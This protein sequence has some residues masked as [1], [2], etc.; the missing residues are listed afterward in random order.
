MKKT[1][2][3]IFAFVIGCL[4]FTSCQDP[5]AN[6]TVAKPGSYDQLA[7]Q[8]TTGF[9]AALKT[10]ISPLTIQANN[11][12]QQQSL[13]TCSSVLNLADTTARTQYQIQFS[14]VAS[15]VPF[16]TI[17]ITFDGKA[18]SDVT[19]GCKQFND[20][21]KT[22][23]KNAVQQTV[24]VRLLSFIVKKGLK[25]VYTSKTATLL[26]T[27]NNYAPT[28]V[29]DVVS[30]PM[31]SSI[32]IAVLTND[33]DPEKDA[34][35]TVSTTTPLHGTTVVNSDGT[36][37]YTPT[38]GY[39]GVDVFSYTISDG[40]GNTATANVDVTVMSILP[41]TA[42]TPRPY[43]IIGL[44]DGKWSNSAAGVG[45]SIYP[46]SVV[47]GNK[48]NIAGDGEFTF[49]GY[50]SASKGFKLIRDFGNWDE[51]WGMT[52]TAY[53]HNNGG[54]GNITVPADG[55]Y[56]ITLNSITNTLT[57]LPT[58]VTP[59][60]YTQIGLIGAFNSWGADVVM[61]PAE[62]TNN[63]VWYTTQT[64]TS[65]GGCKF[66]ANGGWTTSWGGNSFPVGMSGG[67][68]PAK[69][70]TYKVLFNDVE[71]CYYFIKQ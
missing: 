14:K 58:L 46:M 23:N 47:S 1:I 50:F 33:T 37:T 60:T 42:V 70:G 6:Q 20:S 48:Y 68:I 16:I 18:G 5:Y 43:Y 35:S 62:T 7:L 63:H 66:R 8:D 25:T 21:I 45:V 49:T 29:N 56:T 40:N 36:V 71:G 19:V 67:D 64:F 65:D 44:G 9:A 39:S 53:I 55:Y 2:K 15:F 57:V 17:P 54:S 52:G 31:N 3:Y 10:G 13:L 27:P 51:Q 41:Y 26:V 38:T 59:T 28:A 61:T 32:S 22:Y 69:A 4:A 30:L 11:L 12:G 34:L 24:Y